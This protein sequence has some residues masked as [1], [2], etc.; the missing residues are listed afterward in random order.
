MYI[1]VEMPKKNELKLAAH[2]TSRAFDKP[3]GLPTARFPSALIVLCCLCNTCSYT[4]EFATFAV[5]FR[6]VHKWNEADSTIFCAGL[7]GGLGWFEIIVR[8]PFRK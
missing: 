5:Y 1:H 8:D 2:V 4:I 3:E 7:S 6:Q